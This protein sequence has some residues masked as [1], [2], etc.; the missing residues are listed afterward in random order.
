MEPGKRSSNCAARESAE[1]RCPPPVS[2]DRKSTLRGLSPPIA[3]AIAVAAVA[4]GSFAL[5]SAVLVLELLVQSVMFESAGV[6][7]SVVGSEPPAAAAAAL[8]PSPIALP[9]MAAEGDSEGDGTMVLFSS[10]AGLGICT[11]VD[12]VPVPVGPD[13]AGPE[14]LPDRGGRPA[15]PV[16]VFV[17]TS[18]EVATSTASSTVAIV[19]V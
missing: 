11:G 19:T 16:P 5:P 3:V 6:S 1:A 13:P 10:V 14:P 7:V 18:P 8:V 12:G 17:P 9:N 15:S 4:V 2:D